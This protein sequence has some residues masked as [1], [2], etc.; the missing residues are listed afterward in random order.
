M[1]LE[2]IRCCFGASAGISIFSSCRSCLWRNPPQIFPLKE[3]LDFQI[4][5]FWEKEG[6]GAGEANKKLGLAMA[7]PWPGSKWAHL[8]P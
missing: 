6:T 7:L 5:F 8:G 4:C 1:D 3:R 2:I